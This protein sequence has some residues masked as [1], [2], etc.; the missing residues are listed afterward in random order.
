[1]V[2]WPSPRRR[3]PADVEGKQKVGEA[4]WPPLPVL[5]CICS[6]ERAS[7]VT[8]MICSVCVMRKG[9]CD[10]VRGIESKLRA[11]RVTRTQL[12]VLTCV[13]VC[14]HLENV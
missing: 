3:G 1:M 10:V 7:T 11:T 5:W 14:V 13:R 8:R 12:C 9:A 6:V 4:C 2:Q